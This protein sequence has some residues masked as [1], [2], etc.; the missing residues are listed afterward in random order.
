MRMEPLAYL[1]EIEVGMRITEEGPIFFGLDEVNKAVRGG[2]SM[3]EMREGAV[4]TT[5]VGEDAENVQLALTG[6][7]IK[8]VIAE[9]RGPIRID[10]RKHWWKLW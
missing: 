9:R 1:K 4:I 7:S 3:M 2:E 6:Y 10:E 5:R 8:V